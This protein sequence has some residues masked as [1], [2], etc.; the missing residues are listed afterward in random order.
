MECDGFSTFLYVIIVQRKSSLPRFV[1]QFFRDLQTEGHFGHPFGILLDA[2]EEAPVRFVC[3]L[4]AP[5]Q[6]LTIQLGL[7]FLSK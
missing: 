2:E 1:I 6:T 4:D 5:W 7:K 3:F